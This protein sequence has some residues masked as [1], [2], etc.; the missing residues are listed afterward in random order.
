MSASKAVNSAVGLIAA[1]AIS[2]TFYSFYQTDLF[3]RTKLRFRTE[4]VPLVNQEGVP[5]I[6]NPAVKK[7]L[8]RAFESR[9]GGV[10]L[11]YAPPGS[12]KTTYLARTATEFKKKGH[13][14]EFI[15]CV[16]SKE[17]LYD[18]LTIPSTSMLLSNVLPRGTIIV[19]DQVES[20]IW[21][22]NLRSLIKEVALDSRKH[23]NYNVVICV[24]SIE[25]AKKVLALNGNDKIKSMCV[26]QYFKWDRDLVTKFVKES[27]QY[28]LWSHEDK[29]KLIELA[30]FAGA[31]GFLFGLEDIAEPLAASIL[32]EP[33]VLA[34]AKKYAEE[35]EKV[36]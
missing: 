22:E 1:S 34:S 4:P 18:C 15:S 9:F 29:V 16:A 36:I 27:A 23:K 17:H 33:A 32:Q 28:K 20:S 14:V 10:H 31:P 13:H 19:F 30:A 26:T 7:H 3:T 6:T 21:S 24:S 25:V 5:F 8:D 2:Y 35:W 12:G 11:M